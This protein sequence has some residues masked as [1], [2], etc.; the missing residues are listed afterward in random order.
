MNSNSIRSNICCFKTL[1]TADV[2]T[3]I[4]APA[5]KSIKKCVVLN[6]AKKK[7]KR[8]CTSLTDPVLRKKVLNTSYID[9]LY[10]PGVT[11]DASSDT[12]LFNFD[13]MKNLKNKQNLPHQETTPRLIKNI[14][15]SAKFIVIVRNPMDRLYSIYNDWFSRMKFSERSSNDEPAI[16]YKSKNNFETEKVSE[17]NNN[18]TVKFSES[19]NNNVTMEFFKSSKNDGSVKFSKISNNKNSTVKFPKSSSNRAVKFPRKTDIFKKNRKAM[20]KKASIGPE[21]DFHKLTVD[22]IEWFNKCSDEVNKDINR[23]KAH[24]KKETKTKTHNKK[25]TEGAFGREVRGDRDK[26]LFWN[27]NSS[28]LDRF[29]TELQIGI[30]GPTIEEWLKVFSKNNFKV[31]TFE[32]YSFNKEEIV[33]EIF[34]FLGLQRVKTLKQVDKIQGSFYTVDI[35]RKDDVPK[36]VRPMLDKTR[37]ILQKFYKPYNDILFNHFGNDALMYN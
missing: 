30:Y 34:D 21:D 15:P 32:Q 9:D 2:Y 27:S 10:H 25:G 33:N 3:P 22:A 14:L 23:N 29:I 8:S 35:F 36:P 19:S 31:V 24:A 6:N 7:Y 37:K 5:S 28:R 26:C 16:F 18:G 4:F 20:L 12:L 1:S 13:W 17:S 11:L